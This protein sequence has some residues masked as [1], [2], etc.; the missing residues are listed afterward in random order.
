MQTSRKKMVKDSFR[1]E[2]Y[3]E[4]LEK[5]KLENKKLKEQLNEKERE[6]KEKQVFIMNTLEAVNKSKDAQQKHYEEIIRKLSEK[7]IIQRKLIERPS[8]LSSE[9]S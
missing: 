9:C 6:L 8:I 1:K 7:V 3:Q 5:L 2:L 4:A